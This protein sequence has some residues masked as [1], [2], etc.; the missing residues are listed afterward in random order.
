MSTD[1]YVFS[2]SE[3]PQD[4]NLETPFTSLQY[5]YVNDINSS[6][7]GSN[8]L[9]LVQFDLSSIYNSAGFLNPSEMYI[10]IPIC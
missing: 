7:Y 3:A 4:F 6:V 5:N 1:S 9:A 10:A 2:K 8:G